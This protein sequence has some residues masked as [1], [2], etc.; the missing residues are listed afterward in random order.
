[1]LMQALP[2]CFKGLIDDS[3]S[4]CRKSIVCTHTSLRKHEHMGQ[5]L[6]EAEL[7]NYV[8]IDYG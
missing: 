6:I 3:C 8:S 5:Q 1:M 7:S 2:K 4:L